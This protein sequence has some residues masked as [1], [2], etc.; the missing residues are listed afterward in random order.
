MFTTHSLVCFLA[1]LPIARSFPMWNN[2]PAFTPGFPY[3]SQPV[4]G[5]NLGGWLVIEPWITPSLF[6]NTGNSAIVDE[7]TF[8]QYQDYNV[9]Q[10]ALLN[11]WNTW[12]TEGDFQAIAG[13][14][15][16][17]V[18]IPIGYWA[19]NVAPGEPFIQGQHSY[20]LKAVGWAA[21]YNLKVI[22]DL[23]G[24]PGSQNGHASFDNSG[25]RLPSPKWQ[26][27]QT[28]IGRTNKVI[29]QLAY[30]FRSSSNVV[31][32]IAPLNDTGT[33]PTET[34]GNIPTPVLASYDDI[35]KIHPP[36]Y[37]TG[38]RSNIV[39]L[40]HDA[41]QPLS[42]WDGFMPQGQFVGVA[43]DTHIYQMFSY[44]TVSL[45]DGGHIQSACG[46]AGRLSDYN[47][48]Q[49]WTIVGEWTPAMTDCA[50][51]LNGRGV[52][53]RYDGSI[54]PGAPSFGSCNGLTGPGWSFSQDY[55]NFLRQFMG[56]AGCDADNGVYFGQVITYEKGSGWI[57]WTWKTE[58]AD[59][60]SYSAGLRYGW[61][62]SDPTQRLY[63]NICWLMLR[64]AR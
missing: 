20:L 50:K 29:K 56:G 39:V 5:V 55:K 26:T 15:L 36:R 34:S 33:T 53:A 30:E 2:Q 12:I 57:Q 9:A 22:I 1:T 19:Y 23:H 52:G 61:I 54:N 11:H 3:G 49:L 21:K 51:Y 25:Q 35:L 7:W 10:A 32:V 40:I 14:G 59:E 48:N 58:S 27:D 6:E 4:R 64:I 45:D 43:M 38:L 13:A 42:Y 28:N 37:P 46:N 60:W 44:D 41:F 24:A 17:H 16:N 62:P 31:S 63:P 8:G 18:R 47:Q